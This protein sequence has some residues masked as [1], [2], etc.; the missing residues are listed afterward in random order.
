MTPKIVD[1]EA[2][3]MDIINAA[4]KVFSTKGMV[5]AKMAD[6]AL[7]A[8]VGKGTIYE[9]FRSKE[10]VFA[11]GFQIFFQE[12][13]QQIEGAIKSTSDPVEQLRF[14][15]NV[16]FKNFLYHGSDMAMVMMDYW[17]EGIRNK[18]ENILNA[19]NL[20]KLYSE[21]RTIIK[22]ILDNGMREGVFRKVD[23]HHV[24]SLLIGAL[25]GLMLQW[26]MDHKIID[27]DKATESVIDLFINCLYIK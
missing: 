2:K 3:K 14:L 6:I 27:L 26:I 20:R 15:I 13:Q 23:S 11:S 8:G 16:S 18:D 1:K 12:M 19:I 22:T 25:D 4:V 9:Y 10:D 7:E 24:A 21:F 17:A 5:K